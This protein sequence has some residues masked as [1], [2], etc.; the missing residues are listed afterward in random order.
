ME[1]IFQ[2]YICQKKIQLES[3]YVAGGSSK[4]LG[5]GAAEC[6]YVRFQASAL[7][8]TRQRVPAVHEL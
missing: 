4:G 7:E 1:S 6:S 3:P 5:I 2:F 8:Q